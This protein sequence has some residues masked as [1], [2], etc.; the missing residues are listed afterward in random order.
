V[1]E[2]TVNDLNTFTRIYLGD[3]HEDMALGLKALQDA[4]VMLYEVRHDGRNWVAYTWR[5]HA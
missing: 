2:D 1:R 4:G 5:G 3:T